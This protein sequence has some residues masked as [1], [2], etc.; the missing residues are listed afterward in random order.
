MSSPLVLPVSL[1]T[2]P[3]PP[4]VEEACSVFADL[5]G[6]AHRLAITHKPTMDETT[7]RGVW[8]AINAVWFWGGNSETHPRIDPTQS[9]HY[10]LAAGQ[11]QRRMDAHAASFLAI[12]AKGCPLLVPCMGADLCGLML[13]VS[14]VGPSGAIFDAYLLSGNTSLTTCP[15][16]AN[17]VVDALRWRLRVGALVS[18]DP[19]IALQRWTVG[20]RPY[21]V[22]HAPDATSA[23]VLAAAFD[24]ATPHEA[25]TMLD[26]T[27]RTEVFEATTACA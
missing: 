16:S 6:V 2:L 21:D 25:R 8:P 19:T 10:K 13:H 22:W 3:T 20:T 14:Y 17:A 11:L 9:A 23:L 24:S 15:T 18:T 26:G 12:V 5:L 1:D 4:W 27:I 7:Q